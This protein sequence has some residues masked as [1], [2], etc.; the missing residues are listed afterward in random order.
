MDIVETRYP[1]RIERFARQRDSGGA[2]VH[3]GGDGVIRETVFRVPMSLSVLSQHR[4]A[5][6][7]GMAGAEEGKS[8]RQQ[9]IG[10]DGSA[11]GLGSIAGCKVNSGEC[12][13]L[14]TPGGGG[15]GRKSGT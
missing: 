5:G 9:V 8:G 15:W 11:L 3:L 13:I 10:V 1:V 12:L 2:G 7:Y 6:S 4:M 14:E